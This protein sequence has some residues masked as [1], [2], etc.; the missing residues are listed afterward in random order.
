MTI[1]SVKMV[2]LVG[3]LYDLILGAVFALFFKTVY[4]LFGTELPNHAGYIQLAAAYIFIFGIGFYFVY[5]DP[6][7]NRAIIAL[8]ILM[9]LAFCVVV[10]GHLLVDTIPSFYIPVA[11]L[12]V[13][14]LA[15]FL[16]AYKA[17]RE[18]AG[19]RDS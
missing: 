18:P 15:L 16:A 4:A 11:V 8:G 5:R 2:F 13:V 3:A 19:A 17:V 7:R 6:H 14:F 12:D 1:K 9:K 10:F